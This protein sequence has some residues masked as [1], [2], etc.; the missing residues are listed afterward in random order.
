MEMLNTMTDMLSLANIKNVGRYFKTPN[1]QPLQAMIAAPQT[2]D[3]MAVA[4]QAQLE[5]VRAELRQIRRPAGLE[6][7]KLQEEN[8]F[9]HAELDARKTYDAANCRSTPPSPAS[10]PRQIEQ[11]MQQDQP[12]RSR[13]SISRSRSTT[14]RSR[15][16]S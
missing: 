12:R 4:A 8:A 10:T 13:R 9:K 1:P 7:N 14:T 2:P 11:E 16:T 6:R 3:P 5:K 15:S